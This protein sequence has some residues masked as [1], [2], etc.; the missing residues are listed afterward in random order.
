MSFSAVLQSYHGDEKVLMKGYVQCNAVYCWKNFRLQRGSNPGPLDQMAGGKPTE[1]A[2]LYS[3]KSSVMWKRM[4]KDFRESA[5]G[6]TKTSLLIN[7]V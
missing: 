4:K 6:M 1:L 3:T 7:I 5:M 2:G